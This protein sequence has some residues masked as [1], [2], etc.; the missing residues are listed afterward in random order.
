MPSAFER[1]CTGEFFALLLRRSAWS[2]ES[3]GLRE[4]PAGDSAKCLLSVLLFPA[5][6]LGENTLPVLVVDS[7]ASRWPHPSSV[8][9]GL[10]GANMG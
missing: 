9:E 7:W 3:G 6:G 5:Q 8:G 10:L 2:R 1:V 4:Q